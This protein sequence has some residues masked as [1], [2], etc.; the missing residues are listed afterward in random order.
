MTFPQNK[1]PPT[2]IEL[3]NKTADYH[4]FIAPSSFGKDS[5]SKDENVF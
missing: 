1:E 3:F 5:L 2:K 4:G